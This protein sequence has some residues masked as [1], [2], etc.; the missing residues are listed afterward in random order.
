MIK[1]TQLE[2]QAIGRLANP[3]R[4][5]LEDLMVPDFYG[6][7][8]HQLAAYVIETYDLGQLDGVKS[9]TAAHVLDFTCQFNAQTLRVTGKIIRQ[10]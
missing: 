6:D 2:K 8:P 3:T 9:T 5:A 10:V 4:L 1:L 7:T